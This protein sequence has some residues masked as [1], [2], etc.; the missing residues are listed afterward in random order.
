MI[1]DEWLFV[2]GKSGFSVSYGLIGTNSYAMPV[3]VT[4]QG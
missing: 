4:A 1:Y 3:T 2:A